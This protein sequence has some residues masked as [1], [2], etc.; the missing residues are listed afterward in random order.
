MTSTPSTIT[1]TQARTPNPALL[2]AFWFG[3][4]LM[5]GAVLGLSLQA[6]LTQTSGSAAIGEYAVVAALGAAGAAL[7]QLL[8]GRVAD[9]VR[10]AGGRRT[11][12]YVWGALGAA[13]ALMWF[14]AAPDAL[15]LGIAFV[16]LQ[17][18]VNVAI[19]PYQAVIPDF[20]ARER[21][22]GFSSWFAG[23]QSAGN[24]AGALAATFLHANMALAIT[25]VAALVL[26]CALTVAHARRLPLVPLPAVRTAVISRVF[27][28][29]FI[30]RALLYLGF[31]TL[32]GYLYF[33]VE[34]LPGVRAAGARMDTG[35]LILLFTVAGIAGAA[36][37]ATFGRRSDARVVAGVG[38]SGLALALLTLVATGQF[39]LAAAGSVLAGTAW[40]IFL[41]ADWSIGCR[42]LPPVAMAWG[43]AVWNLSI[44]LP[45]MAAPIAA[46]LAITASQTLTRL[47]PPKV[48]FVLAAAELLV[49]VLWLARLPPGDKRV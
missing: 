37:A 32:L 49:G 11:A 13:V 17:V 33:Y 24:A 40:G 28:D 4:Q 10:R 14:Y 29:L 22:L 43:M 38:G 25:L 39:S 41:A 19:G 36:L 15:Q 48:A 42:L 46:G 21:T 9:A 34:R 26:S 30:S 44:V 35:V 7:T 16:T 20:V 47:A 3:T 27:I 2:G 18:C 1:G 23:L 31:Y 6:R 45:Q 12:F 5:W 8:I